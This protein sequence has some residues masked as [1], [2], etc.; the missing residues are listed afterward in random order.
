MCN[1]QT[2][3]PIPPFLLDDPICVPQDAAAYDG[4]EFDLNT[5]GEHC[6]VVDTCLVPALI[7]LW[8]AG[9]KT[10]SCCCGHGSGSGV[11]G[12]ATKY[13]HEHGMRLDEAP[14]YRI[15]EIVERRRHENE[16]Y[17]RGRHDGLCEAGREDLALAAP[18]EPK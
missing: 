10:T 11:I 5:S 3:L 7:A 12:I 4:G 8:E 16:A 1:R 18:R 15:V 6:L 9:I 14:P 17:E 2:V 13:E